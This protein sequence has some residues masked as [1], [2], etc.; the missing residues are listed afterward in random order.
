M[1]PASAWV[2]AGSLLGLASLLG[3]C[4]SQTK[5]PA[6]VR[7][8]L[9]MMA[10]PAGARA[11]SF[12]GTIQP[13]YQTELGFRVLGRIVA[14][15]VGVGDLVKPGQILAQLDPVVLDLAVRSSEAELAKAQSQLSNAAAAETRGAT[16]FER[17][18]TTQA[19]FD[20]L[21][22]AREAAAASVQQAEAN[23]AKAREQR[24][25]AMLSSD[26]DGVVTTTDAE[27]GQTVSPGQ[28]VM[29]LARTDARDAV[30]DLPEEV[31]Q[32]LAAGAPFAIELQADPSIK[33]T[34]KVREIAPQ[35]DAVTRTRRVRITLDEFTP[36]FR[37][38]ATISATPRALPSDSLIGLP[39]SALLDRDGR[40]FVWVVDPTARTVRT[41]PV[42][43]AHRDE[44][45][46]RI[47][48]G[49]ETGARVVVAGVHSLAEGQAVKIDEGAA[50]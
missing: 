2:L 28:R 39:A 34:G 37:L 17:K 7:P 29:T 43:I 23:L 12:S 13:R 20:A 14:R 10:E 38:G 32:S 19:D 21:K 41:V 35:S 3:G 11:V 8:V 1:K 5:A 15:N 30:V 22:Q 18:V 33:T 49:L 24:G 31:T 36:A 26:L 6:P 4:N 27:V 50:R 47:S 40:T 46:A 48:G 42:E 45:G 9:T 25:Y 44:H 16:L